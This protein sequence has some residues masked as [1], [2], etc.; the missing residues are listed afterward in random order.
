[1]MKN[2]PGFRDG[3]MRPVK[4]ILG[5]ALVIFGIAYVFNIEQM[6]SW[7]DNYPIVFGLILIAAGY[8]N[9]IAGQRFP[10]GPFSMGKGRRNKR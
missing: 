1:M 3:T 10:G 6:I 2:Y 4:K 5:I 7:Y 9:V 8:F